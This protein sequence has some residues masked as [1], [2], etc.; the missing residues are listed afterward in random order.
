MIQQCRQCEL[1]LSERRCTCG[2]VNVDTHIAVSCLCEISV[3]AVGLNTEQLS[4]QQ[5]IVGSM[6]AGKQQRPSAGYIHLR[7]CWINTS[8]QGL[9]DKH[10]NPGLLDKHINLRDCWI[11][12]SIQG[13]LD[14]HINLRDYWINTSIPGIAG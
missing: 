9:L 3:G 14:K 8:I 10:M 6:E 11:N 2:H 5:D 1:N 4:G 12:K 13:L 7:D